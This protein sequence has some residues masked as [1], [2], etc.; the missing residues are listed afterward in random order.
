MHLS[1]KSLI[2]IIGW[3]GPRHNGQW[4]PTSKDFL[5]QM[6][7]ITFIFLFN[8]G[9]NLCMKNVQYCRANSWT[10]RNDDR[11]EVTKKKVR[12]RL[13][14]HLLFVLLIINNYG[15]KMQ[16]CFSL[17][18]LQPRNWLYTCL[19]LRMN[20]LLCGDLSFDSKEST[21]YDLVWI[22]PLLW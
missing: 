17:N 10:F 21:V 20:L 7:C 8:S 18:L 5:S 15:L 2:H 19:T 14:T 9:S 13:L 1:F 6:L 11:H 12:I 3:I 22:V 4:P 16:L